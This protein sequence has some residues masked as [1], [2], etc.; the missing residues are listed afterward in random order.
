MQL[1][2]KSVCRAASGLSLK[3]LDAENVLILA[4]ANTDLEVRSPDS[5][6]DTIRCTANVWKRAPLGFSA[7][8]CWLVDDVRLM[9]RDSHDAGP[10][11]GGEANKATNR[12][13]S[14]GLARFQIVT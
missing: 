9:N 2:A 12:T 6:R 1:T 13:D 5:S 7:W 3:L 10:C 14:R 8:D 11:G 4:H